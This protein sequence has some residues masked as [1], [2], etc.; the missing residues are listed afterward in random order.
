MR[1]R[2][3]LDPGKRPEFGICTSTATVYHA[4]VIIFL[5]F[6][7]F[8][9]LTTPMISI[10]DEAFPKHTFLMN[11]LVQGVKGFLSFLSAPLIGSMSDTFGRKPFLILTV[12][13]TCSPIPLIKLSHWWY[14]TMISIS[15]IF[16]V[17]FSVVLAYVADITSEEER[18]WA[19]GLVQK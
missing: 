17:T 9:L 19:Y 18:S 5:E 14:F 7:A 16:S 10:L 3:L 15:G 6:F 12:T 2:G 4:V 8:G 13:F 11:G 1:R